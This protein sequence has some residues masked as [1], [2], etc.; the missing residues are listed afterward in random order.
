MENIDIN[1]A[2]NIILHSNNLFATNLILDKYPDFIEITNYLGR[3]PLIIAVSRGN[4]QKVNFLIKHG[5]KIDSVDLYGHT[6]LYH[7]C[8]Y[9]TADVLMTILKYGENLGNYPV[10]HCCISSC[11]F[12]CEKKCDMIRNHLQNA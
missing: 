12:Q 8:M 4:V 10:E 5:A 6:P 9:G 3:T 11:T 7:A 2:R 1:V